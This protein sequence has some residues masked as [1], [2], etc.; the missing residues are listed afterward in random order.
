M[1]LVHAGRTVPVRLMPVRDWHLRYG[2]RLMAV[3]AEHL[4]LRYLGLAAGE[5][6]RPD[7]VRHL[8]CRIQMIEFQL[9]GESAFGAMLVLEK[10]RTP[11][12]HPKTLVFKLSGWILVRHNLTVWKP[13]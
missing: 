2:L 10:L 11:R 3:M 4:A 5:R 12:R 6:P 8:L 7:T 1:V 9:I 13:G